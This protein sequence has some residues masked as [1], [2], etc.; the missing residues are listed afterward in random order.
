MSAK[1]SSNLSTT[2]E[3]ML[4]GATQPRK[5]TG[6]QVNFKM[7]LND[8][9]PYLQL[10]TRLAPEDPKI[11]ADKVEIVVGKE[12]RELTQEVLQERQEYFFSQAKKPSVQIIVRSKPSFTSKPYYPLTYY[13]FLCFV[14]VAACSY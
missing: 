4:P 1:Y 8:L 9:I 2:I 13:I 5:I 3:V 11:I 14:N 7:T 10:C 12:R 6:A